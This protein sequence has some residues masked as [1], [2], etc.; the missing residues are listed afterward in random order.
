MCSIYIVL[1][2]FI[3]SKLFNLFITSVAIILVLSA[4][5][6]RFFILMDF[7]IISVDSVNENSAEPLSATPSPPTH[8][9][10]V[11]RLE[12]PPSH[13]ACRSQLYQFIV[14]ARSFLCLGLSTKHLV[15]A[16]QYSRVLGTGALRCGKLGSLEHAE[17]AL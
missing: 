12:R 5:D 15:K 14:S 11:Y 3:I 6:L 16:Y 7:F 2:V 10:L 4:Q 17:V 8:L 1:F 13:P 9:I